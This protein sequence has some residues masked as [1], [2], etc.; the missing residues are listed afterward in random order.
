VNHELFE[1][2]GELYQQSG[3]MDKAIDHYK[4]SLVLDASEPRNHLF[5]ADVQIKAKRYAD[6]VA[7]MEMARQKF[8]DRPQVSYYLAN[9]LTRA[10]RHQDAL[11]IFAKIS[12]EARGREES[13][14]DEDF[15]FQWGATAEQ[16]GDLE[17]AATLMKKAIELN[18]NAPEPYNYLGYMWVD[19]GLNLEEAG[20]L[21]KKAIEMEPKNGAY[22]D[23]LG[24][25]YFKSGKFDEARRELLAALDTLEEEDPVVFEHLA[26]TYEKLGNLKE[27][28]S[29]W[30]KALKLDP[31][32]ADQLREKVA[33]VKK[34]LG[35]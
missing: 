28:I 15:Y 31:A 34:R 19:K 10:K 2:L 8:P 29:F 13:L 35:A 11:A 7:T 5:L 27:A 21:I 24:W 30:E 6:A 18:P 33:A 32:N 9:A 26:D 4:Q 23:S 25:F 17:K 14:L 3:Q 20:T 16:A 1:M 12:E 22:L